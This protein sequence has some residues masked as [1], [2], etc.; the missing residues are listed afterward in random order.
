MKNNNPSTQMLWEQLDNGASPQDIQ[1]SFRPTMNFKEY[2][3]KYL[4]THPELTV[5]QIVRN[6]DISRSYANE[7]I[8]G[9]KKGTRDRIIALCYGAGMNCNELKE[10]LRCAGFT[11][12]VPRV[13]R[14]AC[15]AYVF[16]HPRN[17][18]SIANVN[19]YLESNGEPLLCASKE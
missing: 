4:A 3:D 19:L 11:E 7:I 13:R 15:I 10:G 17:F 18:P 12:L 8:A 16:K 2:M 5:A 1:D 9:K 6:S 14:D